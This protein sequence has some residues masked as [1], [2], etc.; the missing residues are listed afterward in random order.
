MKLVS[1]IFNEI[2]QRESREDIISVLRFNSSWHLRHILLS[3]FHP[4]VEF[5]IKQIPA[6]T[7][8]DAPD[9]FGY[10]SLAQELTRVYLFQKDNPKVSPSLTQERKEELLIQILES[11]DKTEAEV[12]AN[13][14]MR[15]LK[16]KG[17]T[18]D[19]VKEAFPDLLP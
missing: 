14:I 7:P 8:T 9:G 17:L 4:N 11:L 1:E 12:F 13:M 19:I 15:D 3:T 6:Y 5:V 10:T 16:V 18:Y 2:E